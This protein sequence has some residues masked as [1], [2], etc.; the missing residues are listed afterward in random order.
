MSAP[1]LFDPARHEPLADI[2]WDASRVREAIRSIAHDALRRFEPGL[3]WP[4]HAL[5]EPDLPDER[6]WML[7]MG[8]GGV[9][10]GLHTLRRA[11]AI[12]GGLQ[13]LD[14]LVPALV[15]NNRATTDRW[16]HGTASYLMGDSGLLLL[17]WAL[18]RDPAVADRLFDTV[19]GNLEHPAL[20]ALWGSPGSVLAALHMAEATGDAAWAGLFRRA[21]DILWQQMHFDEALQAW[22][23][24]Q[25]LYGKRRTFLGA[26]HG[27]VGNV[28]P[29][30][31]GAALLPAQTVA[32][33]SDRAL[34]TLQATA[35]HDGEGRANWHPVTELA[36]IGGRAPLVQDC[37]GAPG[38]V[39]RMARAPAS[40]AW[41][42]LLRAAGELTWHAGPLAKGPNL[43][44]GTAGNGQAF[45]ALFGRTGDRLW[46]E[47]AR[48]FAMH[49][50][51]QVEAARE[52]HGQGRYSLWTGDVGVALYAWA[53][54]QGEAHFPTLDR[55]LD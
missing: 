26:G 1:P 35:L 54:L 30:L 38:V 41:D 25:D 43:C 31:R 55:F 23:W 27:F 46:L 15:V 12:D 29:V 21:V 9:L 53:C 14:A 16:G 42:E 17:Q 28:Y 10:L 37:H 32:A 47:R 39:C 19:E 4:T 5:D 3:G 8:A 24:V 45:L 48:A 33:W 36:L 7:Y 2:S 20:E 6:F 13:G 50:I 18:N 44:H 40:P 34:R 22:V 49:A 52:K 51:G 11:G